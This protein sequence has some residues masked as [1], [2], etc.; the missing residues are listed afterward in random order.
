M[1]TNL[2]VLCFGTGLFILFLIYTIIKVGVLSS[3]SQSYYDLKNPLL[4]IG[5]LWIYAG[6]IAYVGETILLF[7]TSILICLV[8]TFPRY[9]DKIEGIIHTNAARG[10]IIIGMLSL[11][12]DFG[13]WYMVIIFL[14]FTGITEFWLKYKNHTYWTEVVALFVISTSLFGVIQYGW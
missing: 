4:F 8:G 7:I 6:S 2:F 13:L 1:E 11:W 9:R 12:I 5:P 3:I 10:G 14:I